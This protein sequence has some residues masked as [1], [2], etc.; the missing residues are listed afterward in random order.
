MTKY[1]PKNL[2]IKNIGFIVVLLL[3]LFIGFSTPWCPDLS[4]LGHKVFMGLIIVLGLWIFKPLDIPFSVSGCLLMTLY[5]VFGIAPVKVFSGF[6]SNA[7]WILIPALF[8]GFVLVKTGLGKRIAYLVIKM[9]RPSYLGLILAWVVIGLT[10]SIFTPS[11]IVRIAIIMPIAINCVEVC[12]LE[13]GSNGAALILL[14]AWA[15]AIMP[16]S[17]W[18]TGS[19]WGPIIMGMFNSIPDLEGLITFQ[20][21]SQ[22]SFL[23]FELITVLVIIGGIFI[24]KPEKPIRITRQDFKAE[25]EKLGPL[26][27]QEKYTAVIL[28]TVFILF[29]TSPLHHISSTA[30]ALAG[31]VAFAVT[32]IIKTPELSSGISWDLVIFIGVAMGI[33]TVFTD[34]GVSEWLAG[35][36]VPS[37]EPVAANPWMFV[38]S[39]SIVLFIWRFVDVAIFIP[40]MAIIIPVLGQIYSSF[41]INPLIWITLFVMAGNCFFLSYQN[42]FALVA[43]SI[44]G[45]KGWTPGQ[46][47]KYGLV[48]FL[49]ALISITVTIPYWI[50]IGMFN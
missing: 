9:F 39:I 22:V 48:Y 40:T 42:M 19:L 11:I 20:S 26:S 10:L 35:I 18:L 32:G 2:S 37:I 47:S 16:G 23:P 13:K 43:E 41:S 46:I 14:T 36:I 12:K 50:S 24:L 5:L 38:F 29:L 1:V 28:T 44:T 3:G 31:L 45:D 15:M 25:Y 34:V 8:F 4:I 49:A 6:T 33:G 30:V 21:W 27:K 7:L 17:G